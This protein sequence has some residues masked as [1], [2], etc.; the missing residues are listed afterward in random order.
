VQG[1]VA[2]LVTAALDGLFGLILGL[3]LIP[4]ATRVIGPLLAMVRR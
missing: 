4:L 3:A 2:W 1:A